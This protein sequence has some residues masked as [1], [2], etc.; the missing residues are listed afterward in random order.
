MI[1]FS[2]GPL[3]FIPALRA[4]FIAEL[5]F[6]PEDV[7]EAPHMEL[8]PAIGAALAQD[9]SRRPVAPFRAVR[10]CWAPASSHGPPKR[11]ALPPCSQTR[12]NGSAGRKRA[13]STASS[14]CRCAQLAGEPCFLGVD[15]GS[16]TTKMVLIDRQGRLVFTHYAN[17]GGNAIGAAR[18]GLEKLREA[19]AA[20][21]QPPQIARSVVTG[22]GEDLI[23]T[24]FGL[25][26]GIVETLAHFRGAKPLTR[27]YPSS[28]TSAART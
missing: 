12:P 9:G 6:G 15:S 18:E 14:G 8:L 16:T 27:T 1:L 22:Y 2:G 11:T 23:R 25:D 24:A 21:E 13:G 19:F 26:E 28:W 17:N 3:T 7:L 10:S 4:A 20:C 5:G